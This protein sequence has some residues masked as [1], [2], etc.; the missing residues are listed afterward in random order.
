[1]LQSEAEGFSQQSVH[2]NSSVCERRIFVQP[3]QRDKQHT[4][5]KAKFWRTFEFTARQSC[6]LSCL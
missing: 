5:G 1:M 6:S 3:G 4:D 2:F